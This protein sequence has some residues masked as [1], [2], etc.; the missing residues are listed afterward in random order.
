MPAAESA[1]YV[2]GQWQA[3][4]GTSW[5][6]PQFAAML[7]EIYQYCGVTSFGNPAALPYAAFSRAGY[8]D[9]IDAVSGNNAYGVS[10]EPGLSYSAGP[11]YD[12]VTGIGVPLG[13]PIATALCPN[14]VPSSAAR[15]ADATARMPE[16]HSTAYIQNVTPSIVGLADLGRRSSAESTAIQL[17]VSS[18]GSASSN[19]QAAIGALRSAGFTIGRTFDNHLVVNATGPSGAVE[20]LFATEMHD[21][22]QAASASEYMPATDITV[23][24]SLAPYVA[25]VVLDNVITFSSRHR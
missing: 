8:A 22:A 24:A 6:A 5:A 11:G 23:P 4:N 14:R 15:A 21:V 18:S 13:M 17:V 16:V 10:G 1:L 2:N 3:D 19:E 9:F 25:G 20:S 7:A 12:N